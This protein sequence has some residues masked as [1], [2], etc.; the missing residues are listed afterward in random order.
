MVNQI[1]KPPLGL[2]PRYIHEAGRAIEI[3]DACQRYSDAEKAIPAEWVAEL[4][5]LLHEQLLFCAL[6]QVY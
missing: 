5:E 3:M 4:R 6:K 2:K 1:I